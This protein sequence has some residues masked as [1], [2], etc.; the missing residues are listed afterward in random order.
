MSGG[1]FL[2]LK[3]PRSAWGFFTSEIISL[4]GR[5]ANTCLRS[6]VYNTFGKRSSRPF[7]LINWIKHYFGP[8]G[9]RFAVMGV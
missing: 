1:V 9:N 8:L 5:S 7:A 2:P 3:P 6:S 4:N